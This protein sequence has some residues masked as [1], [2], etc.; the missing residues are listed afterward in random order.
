MLCSPI[1][2]PP[3]G[4]PAAAWTSPKA[5]FPKAKPGKTEALEKLHKLNNST[6]KRSK[7]TGLVLPRGSL[8]TMRCKAGSAQALRPVTD[9]DFLTPAR[10]S[11]RKSSSVV[12]PRDRRA[13]GKQCCFHTFV[14]STQNRKSCVSQSQARKSRHAGTKQIH[15]SNR[16]TAKHS[17]ANG[18]LLSRGCLM[19]MRCR[20]GSAH[21]LHSNAN[22]DAQQ[23][24][25]WFCPSAA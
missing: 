6:A 20:V 25:S 18:L 1:A 17:K 16:S 10:K 12:H 4:K 24:L 21:A 11:T 19:T 9:N 7:T 13:T 3:R 8:M 14:H 15:Q 22:W 23:R 5:A 2:D